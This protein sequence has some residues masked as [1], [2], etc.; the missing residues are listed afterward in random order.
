MA[1]TDLPVLTQQGAIQ[2]IKPGR[3]LD[4]G[5]DRYQLDLAVAQPE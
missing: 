2:C 4:M 1:M 5:I 3:L